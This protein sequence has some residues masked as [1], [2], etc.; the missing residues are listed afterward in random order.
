MQRNRRLISAWKVGA[1]LAVAALFLLASVV[2]SSLS[3]A[4]PARATTKIKTGGTAYWALPPSTTVNWIFP[5]YPAQYFTLYDETDFQFLMYRPLYWFGP[6]GSAEP[7]IDYPLSLANAP[8]WSNGYKTITITLKGWKF[9]DGQTVDAQSV[10]FWMNMVKA[11]YAN[12]GDY[13]PGPTQYPGN[14]KSYSAPDGATGLK[15]VINLDSRYGT[16]WYLYNELSQITPMTEAWD[17]TSPSAKPGSGGCGAVAKGNMTGAATTKA[18]DAVWTF[19]TDDGG[20]AKSPV[21]AGDLATY[22]T[23]PLW[24]DGVDGPWKLSTF[25]PTTSE[26]SFVPNPKYSG[27]QKPYLSRF[28]ELPFTADTTEYD[29]LEA[30]EPGTAPDVGYVPGPDTPT[31]PKNLGPLQA[32][33]SPAALTPNYNGFVQPN[34]GIFYIPLN[35]HSTLGADGHAGAVYSQLYFREAFQEGVNQTGII[36][37]YAKGYGVP[38]YGPVPVEPASPFAHGVEL[39]AGGPYPFSISN[40][41]K[42]LRDNG[43]KVV[44]NGTDTCIHAGTKPGDCG[45]GIPKGTPLKFLAYW[46]IGAAAVNEMTDYEDSEWHLMGIDV[47][48]KAEPFDEVVKAAVSCYPKATPACHAWDIAWFGGWIYA[49]DY[50][51]TGESIFTTGAAPNYGDYSN[52]KNDALIVETNKSSSLSVFYEWEDYLAEQLPMIWEPNI[53]ALNEV[54]KNLEGVL[55]MNSL[56]TVTPEYWHFK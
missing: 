46:S 52:A 45:A 2:S 17:I 26:N 42:L 35:F 15:V 38:V 18:C 4:T 48:L 41:E 1:G 24:Q 29:A 23:N 7:V 40:G 27:P 37:V 13:I 47:T 12:Y 22:A 25:D 54:N 44:P 6:P 32:G 10:I 30:D 21:M 20:T 8:V 50:M 56:L 5:F 55:P 36:D 28:V 19:D 11:E 16:Y 14:V 31:K 49:P 34:W 33:P 53:G 39:K 9:A 43:W 51:P 3:S